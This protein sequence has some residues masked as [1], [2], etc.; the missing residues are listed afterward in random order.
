MA[1]QRQLSQQAAGTT[2]IVSVECVG[3]LGPLMSQGH[4]KQKQKKTVMVATFEH[5]L[6]LSVAQLH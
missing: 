5:K 3:H 2:V 4:R 6:L 1:C